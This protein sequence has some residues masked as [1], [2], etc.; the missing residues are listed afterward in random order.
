VRVERIGDSI[1][2]QVRDTGPGFSAEASE[3]KGSLGMTV[4][5][6]IATKYRASVSCT[7][8]GGAVVTIVFPALKILVDG[9]EDA[10]ESVT[11]SASS[12]SGR[13]A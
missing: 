11:A 13:L 6:S 5:R 3:K 8:D 9:D 2:F 1:A 4:V 7:N 10:T 12:K